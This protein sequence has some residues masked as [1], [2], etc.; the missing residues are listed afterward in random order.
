LTFLP[1]R[2][3]VVLLRRLLMQRVAK[4]IDDEVK[5]LVL[6]AFE[7]TK[8][9]LTD[10]RDAIEKVASLLLER[11]VIKREDLRNLLGP[12]PFGEEN[13]SFEQLSFQD[14]RKS[15]AGTHN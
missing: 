11:E 10:K 9:L 3:D 12:R 6:M 15:S 8:K 13:T 4:L 2:T 14:E 5:A 1:I 7:R